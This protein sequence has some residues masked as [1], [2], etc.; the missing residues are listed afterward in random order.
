MIENARES[1]RSELVRDIAFLTQQ[2]VREA[3]I[4]CGE[5]FA[6]LQRAL[7]HFR[8][9]HREARRRNAHTELTAYTLVIIYLRAQILG[10]AC[11]PARAAIDAFLDEWRHAFGTE[12]QKG[13]EPA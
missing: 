2:K 3:E 9:L 7:D 8:R 13:Q 6:C 4:S 5:D 11:A 10:P 12:D 1:Y